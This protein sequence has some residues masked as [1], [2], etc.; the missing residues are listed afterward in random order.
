LNGNLLFILLLYITSGVTPY[1]LGKLI[2]W[3]Q[4]KEGALNS[5]ILTLA[6]YSLGKL[7]EWKPSFN[8][9]DDS[10]TGNATAPYSLGK[11]IEWKPQ[12][13]FGEW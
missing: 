11:L 5:L 10:F 6:P 3:K 7:I 8:P 13:T 2:E 1:S 4:T 9:E 12:V